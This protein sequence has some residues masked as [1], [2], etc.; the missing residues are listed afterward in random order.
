MT[1]IATSNQNQNNILNIPLQSITTRAT[2]YIDLLINDVSGFLTGNIN[3][4]FQ[5]QQYGGQTP[6]LQA[7]LILTQL[8]NA[9]L[10]TL[11]GTLLALVNA[12]AIREA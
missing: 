6:V 7:N 8:V 10:Q 3:P 9:Q 12:T 4:Y 2:G 5:A 1:T 11:P